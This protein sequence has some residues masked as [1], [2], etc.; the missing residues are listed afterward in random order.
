MLPV[1]GLLRFESAYLQNPL[2]LELDISVESRAGVWKGQADPHLGSQVVFH[3]SM[4]INLRLIK[5][6][7]SPL[8]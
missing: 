7:D 3:T 4:C 8:K 1:Y 2:A 6:T 5:V